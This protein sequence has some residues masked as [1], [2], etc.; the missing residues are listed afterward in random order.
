MDKDKLS[1]LYYLNREI[2]GIIDRI[3]R[4][5]LRENQLSRCIG[6]DDEIKNEIDYLKNMLTI[7]QKRC[8]EE[9]KRLENFISGIDDSQMRLILSLRYINGLSWQ[10]VAFSIGEY[11][12]SYPRKKHNKF[13]KDFKGDVTL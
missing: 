2:E 9:Q 6:S 8:F 3:E 11:D 7:Q 10:Q 5:T 1:Q 4:L 12:E 13:L